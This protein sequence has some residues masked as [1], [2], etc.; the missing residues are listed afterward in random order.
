MTYIEL[1][2]KYRTREG[3]EVRI[4]AVDSGGKNP[5]HGATLEVGGK[6]VMRMWYAN[7]IWDSTREETGL[8]L[9]EV[10]EKHKRTV[11]VNVY[12]DGWIGDI[13]LNKTEAE[14]NR[15]ELYQIAA[16]LKVELEYEDGEGL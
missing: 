8:D 3:R 2:R 10:R 6:W 12:K 15:E 16:C 14:V 4:Y 5:V 11:W 1:G 9:V 7:G 13:Y